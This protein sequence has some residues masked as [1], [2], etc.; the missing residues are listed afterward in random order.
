M[1]LLNN[2]GANIHLRG[3][4]GGDALHQPAVFGSAE[5]I[6]ILTQHGVDVDSVAKDGYTAL[7]E[8]GADSA[9]VEITKSLIGASIR[10][11]H[12]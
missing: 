1:N 5:R 4:D 9:S 10:H 12:P 6:P 11:S 8:L 7:Y 3:Q 2:A